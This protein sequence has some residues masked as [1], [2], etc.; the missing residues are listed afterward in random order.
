IPQFLEL[1][2]AIAEVK[3]LVLLIDNLEYADQAS[4]ELLLQLVQSGLLRSR[5]AV[6]LLYTPD[7]SFV[8]PFQ[9]LLSLMPFKE[10]VLEALDEEAL[11]K[12]AEVPL[13]V[14]WAKLSDIVRAKL[15]G[16]ATP[17]YLEE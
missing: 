8:G 12:L 1:L 9:K 14:P 4:V 3:P 7:V 5:I 17:I 13:A 15:I 2:T 10:Y 11:S 16:N 6:M